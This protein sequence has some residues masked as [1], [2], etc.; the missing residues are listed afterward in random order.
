MALVDACCSKKKHMIGFVIPCS[1]NNRNNIIRICKFF[2]NKR[3]LKVALIL[4]DKIEYYIHSKIK[5]I[6]NNIKFLKSNSKIVSIKRN[7]GIEFFIKDIKIKWISF[8]DSDCFIDQ[9]NLIKVVNFLNNKNNIDIALINLNTNLGGQIGNKLKNYIILN[10]LN[11][12]RAGTPS[13]IIKKYT[14]KYLFDENFGIG[15]NN[16]SA[17]DTKFL[18]NNFSRN[19]KIID[20]ACIFHPFEEINL[21][22][23][24]RYSF[25]QKK[26]IKNL[27]FPHSIIFFLIISIRPF[28][29]IF[30]SI[31]KLDFKLLKIYF[32]RLRI[33]LYG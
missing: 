12:Y 5:I 21:Q 18:I 32:N 19:I 10:Y 13:I 15:T 1:Y 27:N 22:K 29:G 31:I 23:I 26:L 8:L 4:N 30:I 2:L 24:L 3:Y 25:G 6:S 20:N 28:F 33:L 7:I 16:F 14:I 9:A 17:E 11:I